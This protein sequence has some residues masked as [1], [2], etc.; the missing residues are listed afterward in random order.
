MHQGNGWLRCCFA[1][2]AVCQHWCT[3]KQAELDSQALQRWEDA[4]PRQLDCDWCVYFGR[5]QRGEPY[6]GQL[7]GVIG[8]IELEQCEG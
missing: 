7:H 4:D 1:H 3:S 8:E 5:T 6:M 2:E